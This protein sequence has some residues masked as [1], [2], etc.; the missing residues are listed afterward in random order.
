MRNLWKRQPRKSC[1]F[2]ELFAL[3]A[4]LWKYGEPKAEVGTLCEEH[5]VSAFLFSSLFLCCLWILSTRGVASEQL[6]I[7]KN[8]TENT[9]FPI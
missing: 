3:S 8:L 9:R 1:Q 7:T 5:G 4:S 6:K 2:K